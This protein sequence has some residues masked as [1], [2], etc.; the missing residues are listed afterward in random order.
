[1]NWFLRFLIGLVATGI[2]LVLVVR[3]R[4]VVLQV[5]YI[6]WA[7]AHLGGGGTYY[8]IKLLGLLVM[9]LGILFAFGI[10]KV[11]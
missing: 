5:G 1:M 2:G 9:V 8:F 3:T 11:F 10:I 6:N 7:E 4:K